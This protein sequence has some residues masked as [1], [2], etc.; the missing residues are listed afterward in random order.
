MMRDGHLA[1]NRIQRPERGAFLG[2]AG[3]LHVGLV[4][5]IALV[6]LPFVLVAAIGPLLRVAVERM[7][8]GKHYVPAIAR[9][10]RASLIL[11]SVVVGIEAVVVR[12]SSPG[13]AWLPYVRHGLAI[14]LTVALVWLLCGIV[15]ALEDI[16]LGKLIAAPV[17]DD[18]RIRRAKTQVTLLRRLAVAVIVTFGIAS[19]LMTFPAVRV[20]G[21]GILASAGFLSLVAGLAAQTSLTNVFAGIQL[22]ISDAVRVDDIVVVKGETGRVDDITLT[23]VVVNLLDDRR[24]IVP[25]SHFIKEP[26]ENWT[27]SRDRISGS[28]YFDVDWSTP[29]DLVRDQLDHILAATPLWDRRNSAVQ[30]VDAR[31]GQVRIRLDLSAADTLAL[32]KLQALVREEIVKFLVAHGPDWLPRSR[33]ESVAPMYPGPRDNS[34]ADVESDQD[35]AQT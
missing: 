28:V 9:H 34:L 7:H 8:I 13:D 24:L 21:T 12:I 4:L 33:S 27:R 2:E 5:T 17:T 11:L 22:A 25:S 3:R 16:A 26:F 35:R 10:V 1:H 6:A 14:A 32:F 20:F 29:I 19:I 30:V 18:V 23:Y 15:I 31:G